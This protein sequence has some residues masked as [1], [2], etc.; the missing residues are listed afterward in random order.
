MIQ[1]GAVRPAR[2]FTGTAAGGAGAGA[3]V[4]PGA[5]RGCASAE[6]KSGGVRDG[7][8]DRFWASG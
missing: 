7:R 5:T 1:T 6:A 2:G 3:I 8:V 4:A